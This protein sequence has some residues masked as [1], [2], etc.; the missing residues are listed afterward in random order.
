M[1]GLTEEEIIANFATLLTSDSVD[2]KA[3]DLIFDS[4]DQIMSKLKSETIICE[5]TKKYSPLGP[6]IVTW[7]EKNG[8]LKWYLGSVDNQL[9]SF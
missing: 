7:H 5:L 8:S 9:S 4:E 3:E 1:N 2:D 6:V